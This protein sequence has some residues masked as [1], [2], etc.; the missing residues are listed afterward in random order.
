MQYILKKIKTSQ[1]RVIS[2]NYFHHKKNEKSFISNPKQFF[3]Y[4]INIENGVC[5]R[6]FVSWSITIYHFPLYYEWNYEKKNFHSSFYFFFLSF[7]FYTFCSF[8][9]NIEITSLFEPFVCV[10]ISYFRYIEYL[11]II[12]SRL[13][14]H[15]KM[16]K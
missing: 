10:N 3:K 1:V 5:L 2:Y 14:S 16:I 15:V 12:V 4:S 8:C 13:C 9:F 7:F 11:F 6:T